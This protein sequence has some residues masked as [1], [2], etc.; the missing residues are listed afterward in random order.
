M[1]DKNYKPRHGFDIRVKPPSAK[2][3]KQPAWKRPV[4]KKCEAEGCTEAGDCRTAKSPRDPRSYLWFCA[5][6]AREHNKQWNYFEGMSAQEA[7]TARESNIYGDRPTWGWAKN[8]RAAAAA[9][10]KGAAADMADAF[11]VLGEA[12]K[13]KAVEKGTF[14]EG[15]RLTKLQEGAFETMGL[16]PSA[17][18]SE[19]RKRYA[20]LLR[21]FHPDSN[22]GD[23]SA[24]EQLQAVVKAHQILKKAKIC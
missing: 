22:E 8:E 24:E 16:P 7:K 1:E 18:G 23:R 5:N 17:P 3:K 14:R 13:A 19:I 4:D 11:G 15:K 2:S 21:K 6:H 12:A 20:E 10:T 9:N